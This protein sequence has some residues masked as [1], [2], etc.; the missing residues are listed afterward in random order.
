MDGCIFCKIAK[1]EI[2]CAKIFENEDCI[3]FL[4]IK[5]STE[6]MSLVIPKKH[7][8]SYVF[9]NTDEDIVKLMI[10]A[11]KVSKMLTNFYAIKRV[12]VLFEGIEVNHLHVKLYP[13]KNGENMENLLTSS[14]G[15]PNIEELNKLA[16]EISGFNLL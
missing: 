11:K 6:G 14:K 7:L 16:K 2:P 9:N 10:S 8:D 4:D 5:P 1:G 13:L 3:A 12:A 15:N